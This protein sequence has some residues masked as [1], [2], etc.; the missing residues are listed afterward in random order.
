[1]GEM[2]CCGA[3][4]LWNLGGGGSWWGSIAWTAWRS[5]KKELAFHVRFSSEPY[6]IGTVT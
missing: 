3:V 4:H 5:G 1:M 6:G 2:G